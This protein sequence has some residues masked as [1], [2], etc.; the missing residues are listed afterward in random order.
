MDGYTRE[1][2]ISGKSKSKD[3]ILLNCTQYIFPA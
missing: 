1:I 3:T 2:N